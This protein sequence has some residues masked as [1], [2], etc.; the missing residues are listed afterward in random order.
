V[1]AF[2]QVFQLVH[3]CFQ[4]T[5]NIENQHMFLSSCPKDMASYA[6]AC[7]IRERKPEQAVEFLE[8]GRDILFA[9]VRG[10]TISVAHLASVDRSLAERYASIA[11]QIRSRSTRLASRPPATGLTSL[12]EYMKHNI[13][14][15]MQDREHAKLVSQ[16]DQALAQ[17]RSKPGFEQFPFPIKYADLEDAAR[18]GPII[19]FIAGRE[20]GYALIMSNTTGKQLLTVEL[21]RAN[22]GTISDLSTRFDHAIRNQVGAQ[23]E[24]SIEQLKNVLG[25]LAGI[26]GTPV[27]DELQRV[28]VNVGA[29][30][31]LSPAGEFC[32]LPLHAIL[33]IRQKYVPS[34]APTLSGLI[35]ARKRDDLKTGKQNLLL[36]AESTKDRPLKLKDEIAQV[37]ALELAFGISLSSLLEE[38]TTKAA[39]VSQLQHHTMV[40]FACHGE[41]AKYPLQSAFELHNKVKLTILDLLEID[42]TLN[43][44]LA[45]LS[46]C[47]GASRNPKV[48]PF[49]ARNEAIN[50]AGCLQL[51]GVRNVIG[52]M[53]DMNDQWGPKITEFF[54]REMLA[55]N[56]KHPADAI[57]SAMR[58]LAKL[59]KKEGPSMWDCVNF[60]H[61]GV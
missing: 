25:E 27:C 2:I 53:F 30:I 1:E 23:A 28:G 9:R 43:L 50:L 47:E 40:H 10:L 44:D 46:I 17:I 22:F 57:Q 45:F 58:S 48:E 49:P 20:T 60:I 8:Q 35:H 52:T 42:K 54:Y 21:P 56:G 39:V 11:S 31:W 18:D 19:M 3:K 16:L 34:Y 6:A 15:D 55:E 5:H 36:V 51:C 26:V 24:D 33:P 13:M 32:R 12:E 41:L 14:L 29:R 7:A 61:I 38:Q 59:P 37:K 4:T